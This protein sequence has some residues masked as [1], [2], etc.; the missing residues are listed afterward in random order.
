M[1]NIAHTDL[2]VTGMH[3]ANCSTRLEKA[4]N[5]LPDVAASVSIATERAHISYDADKI[6]IAE[7]VK[8]IQT[9]GFD[10]HPL[11]DFAAEKQARAAALQSQQRQFIIAALL[12]SPMLLAMLLM[13]AGIHF[14][15]PGW[16]QFLLATPVQFWI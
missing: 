9:T 4:L 14:M 2:Q 16:L 8:A 11:R 13:F 10:A 12:T 15:L 6:S 5:Q 7:L 3:C 1:K